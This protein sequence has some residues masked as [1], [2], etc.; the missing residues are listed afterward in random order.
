MIKTD[1]CVSLYASDSNEAARFCK[2][3]LGLK[4]EY[5]HPNCVEFEYVGI[6]IGTTPRPSA[7]K[8]PER[9]CEENG[10]QA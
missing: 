4:K 8:V 1:W 6:G 2:E 10:F 7:R 3:T 9:S 5:E